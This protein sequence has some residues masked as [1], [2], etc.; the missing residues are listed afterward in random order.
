VSWPGH[1]RLGPPQCPGV[2]SAERTEPIGLTLSA[3][4]GRLSRRFRYVCQTD[5]SQCP[6]HS[7][8]LMPTDGP[9]GDQRGVVQ[10]VATSPLLT[11]W[12]LA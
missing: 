4:T 9:D 5:P 6:S 8:T 11:L 12:L 2:R 7:C 10:R 3:A 1:S